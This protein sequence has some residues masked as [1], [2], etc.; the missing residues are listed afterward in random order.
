[1]RRTLTAVALTLLSVSVFAQDV[2]TDY[3]KSVNF[4]AIKTFSIK[5][6][7]TWGNPL[8]E[9]RV[10]QEFDKAITEKGWTMTTDDAKADALV[11][12]HGATE[13]KKSLETFYSG[14]VYGAYGYG[15][16]AG[17]G[18]GVGMGS[19]TT[20]MSEFTMGTLVVDMFDAR[21]KKLIFRG[22]ASDE[23]SDKVSKNIKKMEKASDKM[24]KNFPPKP[25]KK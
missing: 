4:A 3:D 19:S 15:G 11:L 22:T 2:Q 12:I 25:D 1:M 14:G 7:T 24:F 5:I 10:L 6:G 16:W 17:Y 21:T 9:S 8:G 13:V 18:V 23:L 20:S